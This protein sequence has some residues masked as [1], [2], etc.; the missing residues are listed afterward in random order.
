MIAVIL[1]GI[2][3]VALLI[4][5]V[6]VQSVRRSRLQRRAASLHLSLSRLQ[7]DLS[8][9]VIEKRSELS[10]DD[11]KLAEE[12]LFFRGKSVARTQRLFRSYRHENKAHRIIGITRHAVDH[13][14]PVI[15]HIAHPE[16]LDFYRRYQ[17]ILLEGFEA[18]LPASAF[19]QWLPSKWR[20]AL[21]PKATHDRQLQG[22][23]QWYARRVYELRA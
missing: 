1:I 3:L 11:L 12:L 18:H 9:F 15:S 20:I 4:M 17:Q 19:A 7:T 16:L 10:S 5:L 23:D 14:E 8:R 13:V 21:L 22:L 6:V 2:P